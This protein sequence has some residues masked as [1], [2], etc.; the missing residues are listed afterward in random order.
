M[1]DESFSRRLAMTLMR[2]AQGALPASRQR[3]AEAMRKEMQQI[4]DDRQA[5]RWAA[6]CMFAACAE[7]FETLRI[8][9]L[10]PVGLFVAM[11]VAFKSFD[12]FLATAG[13][14]AYRLNL[15]GA[16]EAL[17]QATPGDDYVRLIPLMEAIPAW[18]HALWVSAGLL[19]LAALALFVLRRRTAYIPVILAL[20]FELLAA[21]LGRPL[22]DATGVVVNPNPSFIA[23]AVIPYFLPLLL[24][25]SLWWDSR[26]PAGLVLS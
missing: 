20:S 2:W 5:L 21:R 12:D 22:I 23:T 16:V 8:I 15:L 10:V 3:W 25:L 11:V 4:G 6:G 7:R 19:Y 18:L 9:L 26:R 17:G 24:V 13:T 1:S 14:I